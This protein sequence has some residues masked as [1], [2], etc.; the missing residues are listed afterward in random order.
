MLFT[1]RH[2]IT[3]TDYTVHV[4]RISTVLEMRGEWVPVQRLMR[5]ALTGLTRK[6]LQRAEII[7]PIRNTSSVI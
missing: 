4:W 7:P 2:S 3:V 1:V 6:I 5:I